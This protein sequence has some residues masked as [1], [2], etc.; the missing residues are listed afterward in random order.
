MVGG[1]TV[2]LSIAVIT[3]LGFD[4]V[5][6]A[7][8]FRRRDG[9]V[10]SV[11]GAAGAPGSSSSSP[12]DVESPSW[13]STGR[14]Y[15]D[16]GAIGAGDTLTT[17]TRAPVRSAEPTRSSVEPGGETNRG[18][19]PE[20]TRPPLTKAPPTRGARPPQSDSAGYTYGPATTAAPVTNS[21]QSTPTGP[22]RGGP[23]GGPPRGGPP[24]GPPPR[25]SSVSITHRT[26]ETIDLG[27]GPQASGATTFVTSA[28]PGNQTF[29]L[30][31]SG[32]VSY[33]QP[34]DLTGVPTSWSVIHTSTVTWYGNPED[35]THPYPPISVPESTSSCVIP[36]SPPKL[37]ISRHPP[38][39]LPHD[40][41]EPRRRLLYHRQA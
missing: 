16:P 39:G 6:G 30:L 38:G 21:G 27:Y 18:P 20:E 34:S 3:G 35:Y 12:T 23:P 14:D 1:R 26:T 7:G 29:T 2:L 9:T 10:D 32:S 11:Q 15:V 17:D 22:P 40:G 8:Q 5:L 28:R 37:T 31:P 13:P 4:N 33:C 25:G 36:I 19:P 24:G 41:Q